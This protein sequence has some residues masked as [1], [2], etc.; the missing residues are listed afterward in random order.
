MLIIKNVLEEAAQIIHI[1]V[2][3]ASKE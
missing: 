1:F 3:T 2:K